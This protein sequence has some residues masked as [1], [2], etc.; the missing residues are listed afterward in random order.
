[1]SLNLDAPQL[2]WT[3]RAAQ[4]LGQQYSNVSVGGLLAGPIRQDAS[5]YNFAYQLGRRSNDLRSLLN[6]DAIGLQTSGIAPDSVTRLLAILQQLGIP[7]VIGRLPSSRLGEQ[8]SIFGSFDVAPQSSSSG[9]AFNLS[10]NGSWNQQTPASSLTNELPAHSG[11]HTNWNGGLQAR[12]TNY[13]GVGI[14][15]ETSLG[16]NRSRNYSD[17]YLSMPSG[18]VLITSTF[19]DGSTSIKPVSFGG[20]SNMNTSQTNTG[21]ELTNQLS[22]FSAS[23]KHRIKF[24][25][26]LRRD[27]F[28]L[29]QQSNTLGSFTFNSLADLDREPVHR[30]PVVGR[31]VQEE[32]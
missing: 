22:W 19:P 10:Y 3:D 24:T 21:T 2:Q 27:A 8:G 6:T 11:D 26:E 1:M 25:T 4:S 9:Q 28:S 12:H 18:T 5:F 23:N 16:L 13:F 32:R 31:F 14:L 29:N 7:T 20:S 15:S 17:P 30:R